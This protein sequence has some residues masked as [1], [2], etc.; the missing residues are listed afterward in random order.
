[1]LAFRKGGWVRSWSLEDRR[2]DCWGGNDVTM[3]CEFTP[4][5]VFRGLSEMVLSSGVGHI[6]KEMGVK[7]SNF[8]STITKGNSIMTLI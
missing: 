2:G 4:Q 1:M 6:T 3:F 8:N 7:L 5:H